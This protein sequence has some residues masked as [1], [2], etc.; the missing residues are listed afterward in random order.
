MTCWM[1]I[2]LWIA[3]WLRETWNLCVFWLPRMDL[4]GT[5]SMA[6]EISFLLGQYLNSNTVPWHGTW[7]AFAG[8]FWEKGGRDFIMTFAEGNSHGNSRFSFQVD[9]MDMGDWPSLRIPFALFWFVFFWFSLVCFVCVF[10]WLFAWLFVCLFDCLFVC[11]FVCLFACLFVCLFFCLFVWKCNRCWM[12]HSTSATSL[13]TFSYP[14]IRYHTFSW[15]LDVL[16]LKTWIW[17]NNWF[18]MV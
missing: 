10:V 14:D 12:I 9:Y 18:S 16:R 7:T 5:L 4:L 13:P 3:L 15:W 11:L 2:V 6:F 8:Y 17:P 1:T